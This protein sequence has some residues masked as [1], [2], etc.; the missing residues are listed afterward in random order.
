MAR[1]AV[2]AAAGAAVVVAVVNVVAL[3]NAVAMNVAGNDRGCR[4]GVDEPCND[5]RKGKQV[6]K[7]TF[8]LV[9]TGMRGIHACMQHLHAK[10]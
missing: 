8:R 5:K 2:G 1:M 9:R 3:V 10:S 6:N 7:V 4:R